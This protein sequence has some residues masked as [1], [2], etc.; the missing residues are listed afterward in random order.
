MKTMAIEIKAG[1][2]IAPSFFD[3]LKYWQS[4]SKTLP[5][6]SFLVYGGEEEQHRKY[7]Y[8]YGWKTFSQIL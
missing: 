1:M 4:L 3:N 7:G 6:N 5:S 8:V 2:T